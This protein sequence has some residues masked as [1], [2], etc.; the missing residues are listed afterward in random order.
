[1]K[2]IYQIVMLCAMSVALVSCGGSSKTADTA[3]E[4]TIEEQLKEGTLGVY[5]LAQKACSSGDFEGAHKCVAHARERSDWD[6]EDYEKVVSYVFSE[7]AK[8]LI[9]N[10]TDNAMARIKMMIAD[11]TP[12]TARPAKDGDWYNTKAD[13]YAKEAGLYNQILSRF[14]DYL[15]SMD[16]VD[17][18]KQIAGKGLAVPYKKTSYYKEHSGWVDPLE[19]DDTQAKEIAEKVK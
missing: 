12:Q 1:M 9:S 15:L 18:A 10:N 5:E 19:Y 6:Y 17:E 11:L 16:M 13:D 7:E 14:V 3:V 8:Y 2:K 4:K